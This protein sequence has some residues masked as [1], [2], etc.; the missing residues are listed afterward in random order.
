MLIRRCEVA[1]AP[2]D[3]RIADGRIA[4]IAPAL[5][6]LPGEILRDAGG[7]ALLPGLSDHHVHLFAAAAALNSVR[8]GPP[9]VRS[10]S[11]LAAALL[12]TPGTGW[13]R[14]VGYHESVA[15][16]LD[17]VA[18]DRW[19]PVRPARIQHR[20]GALWMLNSAAVAV[21]GLDAGVDAPGV[22]RDARG[23][24]TGRLFRLDAWLASE[25]ITQAQFEEVQVFLQG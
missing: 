25:A 12:G 20:T 23:R 6:R 8:C 17:R 19:L 14:G 11:E 18:L 15:G 22:E 3:V 13:L 1:G 10:A 21:I 7:G 16:A 4:A 2:C 24:A 5:A 9:Q